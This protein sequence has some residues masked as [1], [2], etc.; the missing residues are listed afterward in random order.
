MKKTRVG[1]FY[2]GVDAE[3]E[4]SIKSADTIRKSL[5]TSKYEVFNIEILS[6]GTYLFEGQPAEFGACVNDID[7]ALLALHG[8]FG[9]D[10]KLQRKLD[11][12]SIP[13]TGS[14]SLSSAVAFSKLLTKQVFEKFSIKTPAYIVVEKSD[15]LS[16]I[17]LANKAGEVFTSFPQPCVVKPTTA[18]SSLGVSVC[19]TKAEIEKG[20]QEAFQYGEKVLVEEYI[21]GREEVISIVEELRDQDMYVL[22]PIEIAY[23]SGKKVFDFESKYN[24]P[25]K[26]TPLTVFDEDLMARL[27]QEAVRAYEVLRLDDYSKIDIII[28]QTRG[29]F[30]LEANTLPALIPGAPF[31]K[32]LDAVGVSISDF[33]DHLIFRNIK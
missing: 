16:E 5:D 10:G 24:F 26:E 12:H 25:F 29:I 11:E 17:A 32:G 9:E 19:G 6:N 2:G 33:L 8:S 22:P 15:C 3:R 7:I 31:T 13:Y 18:G 30:V 21:T 1:L 27:S 20:L 14:D 4:V 23:P 28:H